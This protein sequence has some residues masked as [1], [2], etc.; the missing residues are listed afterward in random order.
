MYINSL[1]IDNYQVLEDL[2]IKLSKKRDKLKKLEGSY[3]SNIDEDVKYYYEY[4]KVLK[5]KIESLREDF[6]K[7][8]LDQLNEN[9]K[10]YFKKCVKYGYSYDIE[11]K[12]DFNILI[13]SK[14][15]DFKISTGERK[16][17]ILSFI[18]SLSNFYAFDFPIIIDA[19]FSALDPYVTK[20]LIELLKEESEK[21]QIILLTV[22]QSDEINEYLKE[23]SSTYYEI[24]RISERESTIINKKW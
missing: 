18:L 6:L 19:P 12:E 5:K 9:T 2:E 16:S 3:L 8:M 24:N 10:E 1:K 11:I 14:N 13:K 4:C 17:L 21:K 23:I 15:D 7:Y 20:N 22:P